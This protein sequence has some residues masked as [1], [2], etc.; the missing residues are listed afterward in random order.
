MSRADSLAVDAQDSKGSAGGLLGRQIVSEL[1]LVFGRRRNAAVLALIALVPILIGTAVKISAPKPGEGPPFIGQVS[2]NG[3]FLMFT[4]LTVCLPVFLPLAVAIVSG[5]AIAGEANSGTLRYLLTIPVGRSRLLLVKA[6]GIFGYL[7]AAVVAVALVGLITGAVLFGLHSVTLLS[8]DT[9]PLTDGLLRALGVTGFVV[10]DLLGLAAIG[11]FFSTLT[12][13]PVGAMAAT[14]GVA[15][16]FAILDAIPQLG[17]VRVLLLTHHWLDFGDL[18]RSDPRV[19]Q[20][21]RFSL[22]PL[23]YVAVFGSAAWARISTADITS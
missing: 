6:L 23:C 4:A 11:L 2:G 19:A 14:L 13:V 17:P 7:L 20:L 1:G 3:L 15:I 9:V 18:L 12:E 8:G 21:L 10:I 5:D 16:A 22:L